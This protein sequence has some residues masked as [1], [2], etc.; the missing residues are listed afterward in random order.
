MSGSWAGGYRGYE[1][2]MW[3]PG[4]KVCNCSDFRLICPGPWRS[5]VQ[6][7]DGGGVVYASLGDTLPQTALVLTFARCVGGLWWDKIGSQ[8][9]RRAGFHF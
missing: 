4:T 6:V 8:G 7:L 1:P 2:P 3:V 9:V 5:C